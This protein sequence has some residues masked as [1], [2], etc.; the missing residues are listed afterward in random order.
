MDELYGLDDTIS[1]VESIR[2]DAPNTYYVNV[3][4]A[5]SERL[6]RGLRYYEETEK[7]LAKCVTKYMVFFATEGPRVRI[8]EPLF[9]FISTAYL[10]LCM[11]ILYALDSK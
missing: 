5:V 2:K 3:A 10:S 6:V 9:V 4:K 1:L 8:S 11:F 7:G